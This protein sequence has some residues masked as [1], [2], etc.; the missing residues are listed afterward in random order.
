MALY[1]A[2]TG[3]RFS[4]LLD[5]LELIRQQRAQLLGMRIEIREG[6]LAGGLVLGEGLAVAAVV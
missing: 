2:D 3:F 4:M 5:D 1:L 6:L